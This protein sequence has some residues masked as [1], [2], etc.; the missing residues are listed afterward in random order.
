[1]NFWER[2]LAF[3]FFHRFCVNHN[4]Y[5]WCNSNFG[6]TSMSD[7]WHFGW[8]QIKFWTEN[9]FRTS[10]W[11]INFLF[12]GKKSI[13]KEI[14]NLLV[15]IFDDDWTKTF[16]GILAVQ[17]ISLPSENLPDDTGE[18][19][20]STL[21]NPDSKF[22]LTRHKSPHY[23]FDQNKKNRLKIKNWFPDTNWFFT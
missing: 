22:V 18:H 8:F 5:D 11:W 2:I 7:F 4:F 19:S 21:E 15:F 6:K 23:F 16:W 1:M 9:I 17:H 14:R 10:F 20:E 3:I 13:F 12:Q